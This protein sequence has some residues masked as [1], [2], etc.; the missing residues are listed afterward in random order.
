MS[1]I[2]NQHWHVLIVGPPASGKSY[3]C[4]YFNKN[5]KTAY[6][7]DKVRGLHRY[8][9]KHGNPK[10]PTKAEWQLK[11]AELR[12]VLDRPELKELLGKYNELYVFGLADNLAE[13]LGL[14]DK[15]YYLNAN[16]NLLRR[17]LLSKTRDNHF[18]KSKAQR[19][20]ILSEIDASTKEAKQAGFK[21]IDASLSPKRLFSII[22]SK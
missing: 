3:L 9:D 18:G 20:W 16:K 5:G 17:R 15:T 21:L 6:D 1:R 12:W 11:R 8:T 7:T 10:A 19:D 22:T 4:R 2:T 13:L 14:F